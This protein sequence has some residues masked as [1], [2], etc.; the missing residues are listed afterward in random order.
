MREPHKNCKCNPEE[1]K[2]QYIPPSVELCHLALE[3]ARRTKRI[4]AEDTHLPSTQ[5]SMIER[6]EDFV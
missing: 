5:I 2:F 1:S 3:P 6:Q 4:L